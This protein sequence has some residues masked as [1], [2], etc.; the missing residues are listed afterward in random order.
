MGSYPA[1]VIMCTANYPLFL[2]LTDGKPNDLD[3]NEGRHGIEGM[4]MVL[5]EARKEGLSPFCVTI[6]K[7]ANAYLPHLFGPAGLYRHSPV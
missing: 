4:R 7:E 1:N 2:M 3:K 5:S 6:D